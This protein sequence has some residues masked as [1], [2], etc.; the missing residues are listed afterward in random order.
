MTVRVVHDLDVKILRGA[1]SKRSLINRKSS[2]TNRTID[3]YDA[4][5]TKTINIPAATQETILLGDVEAVRGLYIEVSAAC[6]VFLNGSSDG[7][8]LVPAGGVN[9]SAK[10][11]LEASLTSLAINN[12]GVSDLTG[13]VAVWGLAVA[14]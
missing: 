4:A 13:I 8:D 2:T 6:T 5:D 11:F 7:I 14:P 10:L 12:P 1:N 9:D 3:G